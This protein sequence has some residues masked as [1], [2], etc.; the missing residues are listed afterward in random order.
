MTD[1]IL[2]ATASLAGPVVAHVGINFLNLR[3]I[4]RL[5]LPE[6]GADEPTK[7]VDSSHRD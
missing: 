3:S 1:G 2:E 4:G 6:D 5:E 7:F